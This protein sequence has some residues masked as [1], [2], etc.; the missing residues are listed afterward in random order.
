VLG[1]TLKAGQTMDYGLCQGRRGYCVSSAGAVE[2]NGIH[3]DAGDGVA[4]SGGHMFTVAA[5]EDSRIL[6]A[7]VASAD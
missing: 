4:M 5:I 2:I 6:M 7:D 3:V 1:A